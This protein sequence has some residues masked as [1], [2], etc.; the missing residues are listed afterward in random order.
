[1]FSL[2]SAFAILSIFA[3]AA[4]G[5]LQGEITTDRS[6]VTNSCIVVPVGSLQS[7]IGINL[8]APDGARILDGTNSRLRGGRGALRRGLG[9]LPTYHGTEFRL[10]HQDIHFDLSRAISGIGDRRSAEPG[11]SPSGQV[12]LRQAT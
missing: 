7:E 4:N 1:M 11:S 3:A 5:C 10:K 6:D 8:T 2:S 9:R 12:P